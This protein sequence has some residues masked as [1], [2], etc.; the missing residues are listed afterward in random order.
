MTIGDHIAEIARQGIWAS[1][2][3]GWCYEPSNTIF[4]NTIH[5]YIWFLC[6]FL[7]KSPFQASF[8][9]PAFG[10]R[11]LRLRKLQHRT[12]TQLLGF[13][14]RAILPAKTNR[15]LP[16]QRLRHHRT[17][18]QIQN[19]KAGRAMPEFAIILFRSCYQH[20]RNRDGRA[21]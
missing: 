21:W 13:H 9:N 18:H 17:N 12:S 20:E 14:S 19:Q 11:Y 15:F 8:V 2:T 7:R 3:G 4:C 5:L 6:C 1:L 16:A 10:S